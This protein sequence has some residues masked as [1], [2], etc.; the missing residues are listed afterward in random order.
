[1]Q[2]GEEDVKPMGPIEDVVRMLKDDAIESLDKD[3]VQMI[4]SDGIEPTEMQA[5]KEGDPIDI[6]IP[7]QVKPLRRDKKKKGKKNAI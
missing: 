7:D 4:R 3:L 6:K 1:M 5:V 2:L